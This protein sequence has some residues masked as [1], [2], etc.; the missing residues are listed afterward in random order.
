MGHSSQ[1]SP[2]SISSALSDGVR[3]GAGRAGVPRRYGTPILFHWPNIRESVCGFRRPNS[4]PKLLQ[5]EGVPL[6]Q[7]FLLV[8]FLTI[9]PPSCGPVKP[10]F[11]NINR[12]K[13]VLTVGSPHPALSPRFGGEGW[14]E[15]AYACPYKYETLNKRKKKALGAL[16]EVRDLALLKKKLFQ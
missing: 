2:T 1:P 8:L 9:L 13:I 6:P 5:R 16:R 3:P 11:E 12:L 4:S 14:G 10:L 15:G 7:S